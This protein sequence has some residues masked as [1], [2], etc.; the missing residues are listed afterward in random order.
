MAQRRTELELRE[1]EALPLWDGIGNDPEEGV[2]YL[3]AERATAL[4]RC[5]CGCGT[6]IPLPVGPENVHGHN[7]G[8]SVAEGRATITPSVNC[9]GQDCKSHYFVTDNRVVW[10]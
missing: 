6:I 7:W 10:C 2:L 8:L 1:V 5:P 3:D 9:I 4:H